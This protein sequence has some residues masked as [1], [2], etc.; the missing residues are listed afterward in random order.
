MKLTYEEWKQ[1]VE[2]LEEDLQNNQTSVSDKLLDV[3]ILQKLKER[4]MG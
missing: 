3:T 1:I 4:E 2:L